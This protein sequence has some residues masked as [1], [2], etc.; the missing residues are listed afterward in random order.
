MSE[1]IYMF[2]AVLSEDNYTLGKLLLCHVSTQ[3]CRMLMLEAED[4]R[5][6]RILSLF[7]ERMKGG[8]DFH[9]FTSEPSNGPVE[10]QPGGPHR[11]GEAV[12]SSLCL[13]H[14]HT[15]TPIYRLFTCYC[16]GQRS[17]MN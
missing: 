3:N 2:W 6:H 12:W 5:F 7:Y 17:H 13:S 16:R 4:E 14:T 1:M 11:A 15:H 9:K 10:E 8:G